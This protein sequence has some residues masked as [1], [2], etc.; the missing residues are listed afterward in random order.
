MPKPPQQK[1]PADNTPFLFTFTAAMRQELH[2]LE[3]DF[4]PA[5]SSLRDT[6]T[7]IDEALEDVALSHPCSGKVCIL[8]RMLFFVH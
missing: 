7:T 3:H 5:Q 2:A 6:M 4:L 8:L 1:P